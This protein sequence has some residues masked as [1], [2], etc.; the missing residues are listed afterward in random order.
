[1]SQAFTL[2]A[3]KHRWGDFGD[4][5][6]HGMTNHLPRE[7]GSL[8]LERTGPFVP[9]IF[10]PGVSDVIVNDLVKLKL[11]ALLPELLFR[12]VIKARIVQLNWHE[13]PATGEE[14]AVLPESGE[15]EDY[16]LA[17]PHSA[18]LAE[19]LGPL[20]E[21]VA[22]ID[23]EIQG[24]GGGIRLRRFNGQHLVRANIMGGYNF[25]SAQLREA[26]G[27]IAPNDV[28]MQLARN[29]DA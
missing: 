23:A 16:V 10:F 4:I 19:E 12:P 6:V 1:M 18:S 20:W 17:A 26:L 13:W 24:S 8:Q 22:V 9:Q 5:L 15:P 29:S 21:V 27:S 14:P 7:N 25:A 3:P 28:S 11:S 2:S